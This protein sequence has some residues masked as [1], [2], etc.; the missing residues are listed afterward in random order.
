[1]SKPAPA[2]TISA[3]K[4]AIA[5]VFALFVSVALADDASS[6]LGIKEFY[7]GMTKPEYT[8][9][10]EKY[11]GGLEDAKWNAY[12]ALHNDDMKASLACLKKHEK[13]ALTIAGLRFG[14]YSDN[15]MIERFADGKLVR[16]DVLV[17]PDSYAQL[18]DAVTQKYPGITCTQSQASNA[19]GARFANESCE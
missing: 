6:H 17:K 13:P 7:L 12:C 3:V 19:M 10:R 4:L 1:M 2:T 11:S 5:A 18:K 15:L 9:E 16:M 14:S 8:K